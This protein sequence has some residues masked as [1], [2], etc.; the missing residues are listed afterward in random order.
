MNAGACLDRLA[1]TLAGAGWLSLASYEHDPV[2]LRVWHPVLPGLGLSVAAGP[3]GD[4]T[5]WWFVVLPDVL[6][7]PCVQEAA[8][9]AE[10]DRI[11]APWLAAARAGRAATS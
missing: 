10:I 3:I 11:M 5:V 1:A 2:F 8:A 6:L 9:V 4:A 7:A